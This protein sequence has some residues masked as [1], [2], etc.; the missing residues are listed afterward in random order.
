VVTAHIQLILL[1]TGLVTALAIVVFV[2]PRAGVKLVF[3]VEQPDP[4]TLFV[5]RHWGLLVGLVGALLVAAALEPGVRALAMA[6]GA[7]EKLAIAGMIGFGPLKRTAALK[8]IAIGDGTMA[9]LYLL[10]LMGM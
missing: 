3:G 9:V 6:L 7:T 4:A 8:A 2:A 5:T 1:V 10:A